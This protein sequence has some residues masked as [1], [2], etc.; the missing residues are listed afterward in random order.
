LSHSYFWQDDFV[1]IHQASDG[2]SPEFLFQDYHG[3]LMPGQFLLSWLVTELAPL[4]WLPAAGVVAALQVVAS[5]LVLRLVRTLVGDGSLG[6]VALAVYLLSPIAFTASMWW[7]SALQAL[8]LQICMAW[9]LIAHVRY[10]RTGSWPAAASAG[11]A[12][13]VGFF[14]WQKAVLIPLVLVAFTLLVGTLFTDRRLTD[15]M[16]RYSAVLAGYVVLAAAYGAVILVGTQPDGSGIPTPAEL[17][18]LVRLALLETFVPGLFGAMWGADPA[19]ATLAPSP[20]L[21]L[22]LV[23]GQIAGLI[24]AATI[25]VARWPAARAWLLLLGYLLVDVALVAAARLDFVGPIV[26]RDPRYTAD[27]GR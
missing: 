23:A 22:V 6:F 8:P 25:V 9:A 26:G 27:A 14:F 5:L 15:L 21:A 11:V 20:S 17:W 19:G 18:E 4:A 24:V 13:L 3:N 12:I 1:Y 10:L 2:L 7:A 16:R